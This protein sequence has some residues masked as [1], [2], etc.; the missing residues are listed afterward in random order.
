ML[1][2]AGGP[3]RRTCAHWLP[4]RAQT[5]SSG[6][7]AQADMSTRPPTKRTPSRSSRRRCLPI[8]APATLSVEHSP[9]TLT[10]RC[11]GTSDGQSDMA[12]P[13]ARAGNGRY[14]RRAT[15]P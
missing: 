6:L 2:V 3:A 14:S 12:Q 10:T 15:V 5:F 7:H 1:L 13:T 11:Q 8:S 4:G 9:R